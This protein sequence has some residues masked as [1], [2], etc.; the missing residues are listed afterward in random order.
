MNNQEYEELLNAL[1]K[2]AFANMIKVK[3]RRKVSEPFDSSYCHQ[4]DDVKSM[5]DFLEYMAKQMRG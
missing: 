1:G 3:I 4:F 2:E 5:A